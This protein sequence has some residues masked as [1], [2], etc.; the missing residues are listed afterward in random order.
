MNWV[1]DINT[2]NHLQYLQ[3]NLGIYNLHGLPGIA[4]LF[5]DNPYPQYDGQGRH[6]HNLYGIE[7]PRGVGEND[8]STAAIID[9]FQN[10][11][12]SGG[13]WLVAQWGRMLRTDPLRLRNNDPQVACQ[14]IQGIINDCCISIQQTN[15]VEESWHLLTDIDGLYWT[16]TMASKVLHFLTRALLPNH[17][18]HPV[19]IDGAIIIKRLWPLYSAHIPRRSCVS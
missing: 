6:F 7:L 13:V 4:E 15:S 16:D 10:G 3:Q 18:D 12:Y 9:C 11:Y 14:H 19:P 17:N 2:Q 1:N 5:P 8:C